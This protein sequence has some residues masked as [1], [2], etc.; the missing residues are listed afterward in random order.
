M[1][2]RN[3]IEPPAAKVECQGSP[4]S[5]AALDHAR[6]SSTHTL[7]GWRRWLLWPASSSLL[8]GSRRSSPRPAAERRA[9]GLLLWDL[10]RHADTEGTHMAAA[11]LSAA[12]APAG[13]R[14]LDGVGLARA[15]A[16]AGADGQADRA[17]GSPAPPPPMC[18]ACTIRPVARRGRGRHRRGRPPPGRAGECG[19]A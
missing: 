3:S 1:G 10:A 5:S 9:R 11:A 19:F 4:T 12:P 16:T 15:R 17:T 18:A 13:Q 14:A 2:F 6:D 7:A 8:L